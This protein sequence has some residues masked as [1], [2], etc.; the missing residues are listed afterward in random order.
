MS[1]FSLRCVA[2]QTTGV[3]TNENKLLLTEE[4]VQSFRSLINKPSFRIKSI[5]LNDLLEELIWKYKIPIDT[6]LA[7][8]VYMKWTQSYMDDFVVMIKTFTWGLSLYNNH[9]ATL[10]I[11]LGLFELWPQLPVNSA[12]F[13]AALNPESPIYIKDPLLATSIIKKARDMAKNVRYMRWLIGN[14]ENLFWMHANLTN[15][16]DWII[17]DWFQVIRSKRAMG[18]WAEYN[19]Q[20]FKHVLDNFPF[21]H[22]LL[23]EKHADGSI[24]SSHVIEDILHNDLSLEDL[25]SIYKKD[26]FKKILVSR[27]DDT[28]LTLYDKACLLYPKETDLLSDMVSFASDEKNNNNNNNNDVVAA[29]NVSTTATI[30]NTHGIFSSSYFRYRFC[31]HVQDVMFKECGV[32]ISDSALESMYAIE[33]NTGFNLAHIPTGRRP[34]EYLMS[35][36]FLM[37]STI[38]THQSLDAFSINHDLVGNREGSLSVGTNHVWNKWGN[39]DALSCLGIILFITT[40]DQQTGSFIFNGR[41]G[42]TSKLWESGYDNRLFSMNDGNLYISNTNM[43]QLYKIEIDDVGIEIKSISTNIALTTI[44]WPNGPLLTV[45]KSFLTPKEKN[46]VHI[47]SDTININTIMVTNRNR[48]GNDSEDSDDDDENK[49]P[50]KKMKMKSATVCHEIADFFRKGQMHI[51]RIEQS[52]PSRIVATECGEMTKYPYVTFSFGSPFVDIPKDQND[53]DDLEYDKLA[54]GHVKFTNQRSTEE[55]TSETF[56]NWLHQTMLEIFGDKYKVHFGTCSIGKQDVPVGYCYLAYFIRL[57]KTKRG[58]Y[59]CLISESWLPLDIRTSYG[60]SLFFAT[61]ISIDKISKDV[62]VTGGV[63]DYYSSWYRFPLA[64][65]LEKTNHDVSSFKW[66]NYAFKVYS[67]DDQLTQTNTGS[68]CVPQLICQVPHYSPA[69]S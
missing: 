27:P 40:F 62:M 53:N 26:E 21:T 50:K 9:V 39:G 20:V 54:V 44:G 42:F 25:E 69:R 22:D 58:E 12:T 33:N 56:K 46:L 31:R 60:F 15:E 59:K 5:P 18:Y 1:Q 66:N 65:V 55:I 7:R 49:S 11:Q 68:N 16:K 36:R 61:G 14:Q 13:L 23:F 34:G 17:K 35:F 52:I 51:I 24:I 45:A 6:V 29:T 64:W 48:V 8:L 67:F 10:V 63:G 43:S 38:E 19:Q 4:E 3:S 37:P 30:I 41:I 32:H 2:N 57:Q 28:G 47:H